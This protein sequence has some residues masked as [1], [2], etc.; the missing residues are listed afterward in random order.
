MAHT[1]GTLCRGLVFN[2]FGL[3][4]QRVEKTCEIGL[5]RRKCSHTHPGES[6]GKTWLI[7]CRLA[8][9][10]TWFSQM[11]Q[12]ECARPGDRLCSSF[13]RASCA[14]LALEWDVRAPLVSI[15]SRR[16]SG[17]D[18]WNADRPSVHVRPVL[19]LCDATE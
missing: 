2:G 7:S 19:A 17:S 8:A 10:V 16:I 15:S 9:R 11:R 6:F 3:Y 14:P 4:L 5:A 13:A 18:C 12:L 1:G